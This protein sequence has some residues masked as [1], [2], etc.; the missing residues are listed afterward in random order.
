MYLWP[1]WSSG[2]GR[3]GPEARG[4]DRDC[5]EASEGSGQVLGRV[6]AGS[7]QG[8]CRGLTWVKH[9]RRPEP[10]TEPGQGLYLC[11]GQ[12]MDEVGASARISPRSEPLTKLGT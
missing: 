6:S 10:E 4:Q 1:E 12:G 7:E 9:G 11:L 2:L 5:T 8:R 3:V